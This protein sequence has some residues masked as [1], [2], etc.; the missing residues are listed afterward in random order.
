MLAPSPCGVQK[1]LCIC[2]KFAHEYDML[3]DTSKTFCMCIRYKPSAVTMVDVFLN[4]RKL[5]WIPD[6]KYLGVYINECFMDDSDISR[7]RK[8]IYSNGNMIVNRK[9]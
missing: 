4:D 6:H 7:Q 1:I 9:S 5:Q 3:Y 2:E 8:Y